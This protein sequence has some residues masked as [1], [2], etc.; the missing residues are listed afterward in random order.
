MHGARN[1]A[2]L[3]AVS[4]EALLPKDRGYRAGP[5]VDGYVV[6]REVYATFAEGRQNDVPVLTGWNQDDGVAFGDPPKAETFRAQAKRNYGDLAE[7]FLKAFPAATDVQ[8]ALEATRR[9]AGS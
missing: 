3:R 2:E 9:L 8:A 6:P 5:I 7:A 1:I 4:A